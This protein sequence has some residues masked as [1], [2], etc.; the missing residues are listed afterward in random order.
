MTTPTLDRTKHYIIPTGQKTNPCGS[1]LTVWLIKESLPQVRLKMEKRGE[2]TQESALMQNLKLI[3]IFHQEL[4]L[5]RSPENG[6]S[7]VTHPGYS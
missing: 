6:S 4:R 1:G 3:V 2:R 5:S 7:L